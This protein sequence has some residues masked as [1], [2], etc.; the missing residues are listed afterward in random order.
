MIFLC[1]GRADVDVTSLAQTPQGLPKVGDEVT[2][3]GSSIDGRER[4]TIE[5]VAAASG[6][7]PYVVTTQMPVTS[8]RVYLGESLLPA[9]A[10]DNAER[11]QE[12]G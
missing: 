5:E 9:M 7:I 4:I 11:T 12:S 3:V 10:P 1:P 2:L 8:K 6:T